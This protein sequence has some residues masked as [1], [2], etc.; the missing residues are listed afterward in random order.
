VLIQA[1]RTRLIQP[2]PEETTIIHLT[3]MRL[4][5]KLLKGKAK[6]VSIY[7]QVVMLYLEI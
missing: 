5:D 7:F 6:Y 2:M 3:P 1:V 4:V